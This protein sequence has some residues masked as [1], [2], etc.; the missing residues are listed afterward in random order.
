MASN[1]SPDN[2]MSALRASG[3]GQDGSV[4]SQLTSLA[5]QLE[6]LSATNNIL[7]QQAVAYATQSSTT[8]SSGGGSV[9]DSIGSVLGGGLGLSS[10]V[11]GL[12]GLFGGGGSTPPPVTPYVAPLPIQADAGFSNAGGGAPFGVDTA[13]GNSP[14][15]MT[16]ASPTQVNVQVQ[17]MDSQSFLDHS[18]D[19]A[20]AVR[21]AMLESTVLNDVIRGV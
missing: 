20:L 2:L 9:L 1:Q 8:G 14:R 3:A 12:M 15:A 21:Q 7:T 11:T 4:A 17:A 16:G 18:Q 10:L 5:T 19:I 6:Q 13:Q